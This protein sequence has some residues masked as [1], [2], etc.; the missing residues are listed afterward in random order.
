MLICVHIS[1]ISTYLLLRSLIG[2]ISS[3]LCASISEF[4]EA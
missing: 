1:S 4:G 2:L 3:H